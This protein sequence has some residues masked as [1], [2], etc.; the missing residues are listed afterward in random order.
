[1]LLFLMR[2][3]TLK[4]KNCHLI[5]I[6]A[7][8]Q[9]ISKFKHQWVVV[10]KKTELIETNFHTFAEGSKEMLS[11]KQRFEMDNQWPIRQFKQIFRCQNFGRDDH[12]VVDLKKNILGSIRQNSKIDNLIL[13]IKLCNYK[14]QVQNIYRVPHKKCPLFERTP[15]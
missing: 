4:A 11:K 7:S 2:S 5:R 10:W 3:A 8:I 6:I 14:I 1:M 9:M 13:I 12:G 15:F